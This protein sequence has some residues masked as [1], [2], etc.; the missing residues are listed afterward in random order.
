MSGLIITVEISPGELIDKITVL[1]IKNERI[2]DPAKRANVRVELETLAAARDRAIRPSP[3]LAELTARLKT[4]N[5]KLWVIEDDIRDCERAKDFG[6]RFVELARAVYVTNDE[7]AAVKR[8]INDFLGSR[9]V[10]EKSYAA[11]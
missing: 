1:E 10:E 8:R 7:R 2:A 3:E 5:E 9:L 6:P 11:Y 4:V